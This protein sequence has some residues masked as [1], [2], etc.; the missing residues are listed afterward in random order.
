MRSCA[1]RLATAS[2]TLFAEW[3]PI[4]SSQGSDPNAHGA[5]RTPPHMRTDPPHPG[6][7]AHGHTPRAAWRQPRRGMARVPRRIVPSATSGVRVLTARCGPLLAAAETG[8]LA[9]VL[10]ALVEE[11]SPGG[12]ALLLVGQLQ[13]LCTASASSSGHM[14]A[15]SSASSADGPQ[16]EVARGLLEVMRR[17]GR[18]VIVVGSAVDSTQL[19]ACLRAHGGFE[20]LFEMP[21]P[22]PEARRALIATWLPQAP[23]PPPPPPRAPCLSSPAA[24]AWRTR[25]ES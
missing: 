9:V 6:T 17:L 24:A 8:R 21:L 15:P 3:L 25:R 5:P 11:A 22:L 23:P 20:A 14:A 12:A 18:G 19:P 16:A 13:L 2:S 4:C 1:A 7:C 10:R